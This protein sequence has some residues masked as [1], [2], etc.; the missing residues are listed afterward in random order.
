[1]IILNS[2]WHSITRH[3][4]MNNLKRF[5]VDCGSGFVKAGFCGTSKPSH[6]VPTTAIEE[7]QTVKSTRDIFVFVP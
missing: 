6:V 2:L 3:Y 4:E 5:A 1:M 7:K